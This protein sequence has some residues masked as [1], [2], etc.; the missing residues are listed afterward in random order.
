[1]HAR[2]SEALGTE[3]RKPHFKQLRFFVARECDQNTHLI[4]P[5]KILLKTLFKSSQDILSVRLHSAL[6]KQCSLQR[7]KG[8]TVQLME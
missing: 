5:S 1:M 8:S 2:S 4:N 3:G 6:I 7:Q